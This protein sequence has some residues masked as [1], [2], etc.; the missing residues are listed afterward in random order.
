[1]A[2]RKDDGMPI[3]APVPG[4]AEVEPKALARTLGATKVRIT[5]QLEAQELTGL[6]T[7][8]ISPLALLQKRFQVAID[9]S[10]KNPEQIY[11]SGGQRGLTIQISNRELIK[12]T[13][14][15]IARITR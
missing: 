2:T 12:I 7:G 1:M 9:T 14:A 6:Q 4:P 5:S 8:G 13:N 10:A 3:L 15:Q 11:I